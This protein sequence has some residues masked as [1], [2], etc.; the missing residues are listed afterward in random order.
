VAASNML[1]LF[2]KLS[3]NIKPC[4][5]ADRDESRHGR[6]SRHKKTR[7]VEGTKELD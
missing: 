4:A 6:R 5:T 3:A 1:G 2:L 7:A